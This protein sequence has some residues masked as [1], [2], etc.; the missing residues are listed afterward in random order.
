[1]STSRSKRELWADNAPGSRVLVVDDDPLV[2]R[3][4]EQLLEHDGY[5]PVCANQVDQ[6]L[7]LLDEQPFEVVLCDVRMPGQTGLE[8]VEHATEDHPDVAVVVVSGLDDRHVA[9]T[10]L[11]LGAY[12]YVVKPCRP[13]DLFVAV[14]N[15]L[16]R[17]Q[18]DREGLLDRQ[19]MLLAT[20]E[21]R[22][23]LRCANEN[24]EA[25]RQLLR[26]ARR[27]T[28][29][30]LARAAELRNAEIG[31]HLERVG[32]YSEVLAR[33]LGL[34]N[35]RAEGIGFASALHDVGKIGLP[36]DVLLK[37]GPLGPEER[38]TMERHTEIGCALLSDGRDELLELAA[39]IAFTHHERIDG[40]GY[41][42]GL[43]GDAIPLEGRIVAIA[44]AYDALT[45]D[46]PYRAGVSPEEAMR[47]IQLHSGTQF[48]ARLVS[49]FAACLDEINEIRAALLDDPETSWLRGGVA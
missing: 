6:A 29:L 40:A 32:R 38:K 41:P 5:E 47:E 46:R 20:L 8:L 10:A 15:A 35:A 24:L 48:D 31:H 34:G 25:H 26:H 44:D 1:M 43:V 12:D 9:E 7:Q 2:C 17:R 49:M 39:I 37:S 45:S 30:R 18:R 3:S 11:E 28:L 33:R 23:A 22:G 19:R 42:Q 36:D 21:H 27:D 14:A 13:N 4:L 16:R